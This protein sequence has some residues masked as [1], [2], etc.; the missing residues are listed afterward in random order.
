L[1]KYNILKIKWLVIRVSEK[2]TRLK[3]MLRGQRRYLKDNIL[4]RAVN[5]IMTK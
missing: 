3:A 5:I 1:G 4:V 2:W